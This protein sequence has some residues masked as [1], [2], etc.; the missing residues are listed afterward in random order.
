MLGIV[1]EIQDALGEAFRFDDEE[2]TVLHVAKPFCLPARGIIEPV[3][4][5]YGV[6]IFHYHESVKFISARDFARRIR[7]EL[8]TKENLQYGPLSAPGFLMMSIDAKIRVKKS[9]A[10]WAEYLLLR[11]GQ[12]YISGKYQS[13]NNLRWAEKHGG[14]MPP[15]WNDGPQIEASCSEGKNHWSNFRSTLKPK[16]KRNQR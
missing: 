12:L 4:K 6:K 14:I 11:T 2:T 10:S 3:L 16:Q 9:Q 15:A 1:G 5:K 7:V 8:R 13:E